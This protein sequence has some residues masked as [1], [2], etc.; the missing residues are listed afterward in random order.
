MLDTII[1]SDRKILLVF[2]LTECETLVGH[3]LN[4]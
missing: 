3:G 2:C 1:L 4:F